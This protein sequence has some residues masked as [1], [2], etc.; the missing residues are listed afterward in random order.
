MTRRSVLR[1]G[2]SRR[3]DLKAQTLFRAR[4]ESLARLAAY[5]G[6]PL[7]RDADKWRMACA[8]DRYLKRNPARKEGR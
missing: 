8:I 3:L 1:T 4:E 5:L 6:V 7:P 2:I